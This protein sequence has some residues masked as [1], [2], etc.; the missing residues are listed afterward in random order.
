MCE[1][2]GLSETLI[3]TAVRADGERRAGYV[4]VPLPGVDLRLVGDDGADVDA[5]DD[6]TIGEV[7]VRGP[8]LFPGYLNHP[9]ATAE[10]LRDGWF[11]TGDVGTRAP[12]GY[13]R[14]VGRRG[15]RPD[16][17]R[18]A[19]RSAPARSRRR[20]SSILAWARPR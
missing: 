8:N 9:E 3:N 19:S 7:A 6:E 1:R 2:Y 16:Q 13:L 4:G 20:C 15:D 14:I 5:R 11:Y 18:R 17:D 10:A 12:D